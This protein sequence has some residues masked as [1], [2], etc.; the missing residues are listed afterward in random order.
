VA[1]PDHIGARPP[2]EAAFASHTAGAGSYSWQGWRQ[3]AFASALLAALT[4]GCSCVCT[5]LACVLSGVGS[6]PLCSQCC[7]QR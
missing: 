5:Q 6:E 7:L 1:W 2:H 4:A 3:E